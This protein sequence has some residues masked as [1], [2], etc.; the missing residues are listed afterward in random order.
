MNASWFEEL[1]GV[2]RGEL[3]VA[4]NPDLAGRR[5]GVGGE[6][7]DEEHLRC[8][9]AEVFADFGVDERRDLL[10]GSCP[11]HRGHQ[12]DL[13]EF[14]ECVVHPLCEFERCCRVVAKR[15]VGHA[16]QRSAVLEERRGL[17]GGE[18]QH[19][20]FDRVGFAAE[21]VVDDVARVRGTPVRLPPPPAP[22]PCRRAHRWA[23]GGVGRPRPGTRRAVRRAMRAPTAHASV[24]RH[25]GGSGLPGGTDR[26]PTRW[27]SANCCRKRC[28]R[29][30][31]VDNHDQSLPA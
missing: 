7:V 11:E 30:G 27:S 12:V 16:V 20:V 28:R 26:P 5:G 1:R 8:V 14:D 31:L 22:V 25:R 13:V 15:L 24:W 2:L 9:V 21:P 17:A 23:P 4:S 19:G 6:L 29:G 18:H 3:G 10:A